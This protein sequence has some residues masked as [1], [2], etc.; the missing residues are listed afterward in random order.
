M[1]LSEMC[2]TKTRHVTKNDALTV[3]NIVKRKRHGFRNPLRAYQCP[4]C[5]GWHLTPL[6]DGPAPT[7]EPTQ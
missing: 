7:E 4:L 1:K 2:G 5:D 6:P 3:A